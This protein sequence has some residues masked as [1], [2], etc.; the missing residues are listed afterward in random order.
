MQ[1]PSDIVREDAGVSVR[2]SN[3][4]G[5]HAFEGFV[6]TGTDTFVNRPRGISFGVTHNARRDGEACTGAVNVDLVV[7]L[8]TLNCHN[9][10]F[11]LVQ[12][13]QLFWLS[14]FIPPVRDTR[15]TDVHRAWEPG[16]ALHAVAYPG[17]NVSAVHKKGECYRRVIRVHYSS[18]P[19]LVNRRHAYDDCPIPIVAAFRAQLVDAFQLR[20]RTI[21][22]R[23]CWVARSESVPKEYSSMH[24]WHAARIVR[25]QDT[26]WR[27]VGSLTR[28][29]AHV[30]NFFNTSSLPHMRTQL[31]EAARCELVV[32]MHGAGLNLAIAMARPRVLELSRTHIANRNL[33][34]LMKAIGG[35]YHGYVGS[36]RAGTIAAHVSRILGS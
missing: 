3:F 20:A 30:L 28:T 32:G 34:N 13:V 27:R 18:P 7:G 2:C 16:C 23:V 14:R 17:L 4:G 26:L 1:A 11:A 10:W 35:E 24:A 21:P 25:R 5:R 15:V 33:Q 36:V 19:S 22:R 9:L 8:G 12:S 29:D 6:K 31:T